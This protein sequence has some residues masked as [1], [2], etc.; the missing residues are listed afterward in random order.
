[1]SPRRLTAVAVLVATVLSTA[2]CGGRQVRLGAGEDVGFCIGWAEWDALEEPQLADRGEALRWA[3]GGLRIIDR[4]DL[5]VEI[6][7]RRPPA[8]IGPQLERIERELDRYRDAVRSASTPEARIRAAAELASGTFD[9]DADALTAVER[10]R[11]TEE[12]RV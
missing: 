1:M 11:C 10:T 5:R 7:D 3:E 6:A 4:I 8:S 12:D 9:R 2:A